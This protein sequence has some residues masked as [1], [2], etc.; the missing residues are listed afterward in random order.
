MLQPFKSTGFYGLFQ[1]GLER[2]CDDRP[3]VLLQA[4]QTRSGADAALDGELGVARFVD[5]QVARQ[6]AGFGPAGAAVG[7]RPPVHGRVRERHG[8]RGRRRDGTTIHEVVGAGD[9]GAD[10]PG[11]VEFAPAAHVLRIVL[12]V[13]AAHGARADLRPPAEAGDGAGVTPRAAVPA[14]EEL[15]LRTVRD[16]A[17]AAR[18]VERLAVDVKRAVGRELGGRRADRVVEDGDAPGLGTFLHYMM[19]RTFFFSMHARP[20][21]KMPGI[22]KC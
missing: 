15:E 14:F 18:E 7:R 3:E 8:L 4:V 5:R 22:R 2:V 16:C 17:R 9:G 11:G 21:K 20:E 1:T 12:V 19:R 13:G 10:E 6:R